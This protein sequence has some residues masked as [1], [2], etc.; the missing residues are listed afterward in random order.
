M[1]QPMLQSYIHPCMKE[2]VT[3]LRAENSQLKQDPCPNYGSTHRDLKSSLDM[4]VGQKLSW[5]QHKQLA[6]FI[7]KGS[8]RE[9]A[10]REGTSK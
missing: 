5:C 4:S 3:H 7:D 10:S 8:G 9:E 6:F 1:A 2:E